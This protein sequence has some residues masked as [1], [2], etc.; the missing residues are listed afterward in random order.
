MIFDAL[1]Q[2]REKNKN[3]ECTRIFKKRKENVS[4]R[5]VP[6]AKAKFL[7]YLRGEY[8]AIC[9]DSCKMDIVT[10]TF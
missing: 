3:G 5:L 1:F 2:K 4:Q 8:N 6:V 7:L 10:K 9:L